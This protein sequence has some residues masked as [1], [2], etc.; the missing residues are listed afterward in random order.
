MDTHAEGSVER[1]EIVHERLESEAM[2]NRA[3]VNGQ[4]SMVSTPFR[5]NRV[6]GSGFKRMRKHFPPI[7]FG[8]L[9][10]F[11][12][13]FFQSG[14]WL[15]ETIVGVRS[16]VLLLAQHAASSKCIRPGAFRKT[17]NWGV[18]SH[19][20]SGSDFHYIAFITTDSF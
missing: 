20:V 5:K 9:F 11:S 19:K 18:V 8:S 2:Y 10:N 15:V 1:N 17:S 16:E 7:P 14:N 3:M 4:W 12:M 13:V 6:H